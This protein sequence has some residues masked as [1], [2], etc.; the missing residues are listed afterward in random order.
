MEFHVL[1]AGQFRIEARVLENNSKSLPGFV[2]LNSRIKRVQFHSACSW[3]QQRGQHFDSGS[4]PCS[5]G[6]EKRKDFALVDFE[7][8][9]FY[10]RKVAEGLR[11]VLNTDHEY[12]PSFSAILNGL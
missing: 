2:S 6:A 5:V 9:F 3:F 8:N 11:Q 1:V 4:L 7:R 10:G 12:E